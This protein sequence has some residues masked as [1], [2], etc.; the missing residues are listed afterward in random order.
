M[1]ITYK[2]VS[3]M[4]YL[5]YSEHWGRENVDTSEDDE[6]NEENAHGGEVDYL[7]DLGRPIRFL[8][9]AEVEADHEDGLYEDQGL[10]RQVRAGHGGEDGG[11][12]KIRRH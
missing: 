7:D 12:G 11:G 6:Y 8:V 2:T 4:V 3:L 10:E 5:Y 9:T 1:I